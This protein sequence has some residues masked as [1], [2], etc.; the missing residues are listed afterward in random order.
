[1]AYNCVLINSLEAWSDHFISLPYSHCKMLG[2][3]LG[4]CASQTDFESLGA[5]E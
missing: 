4:I 2:L 1:M 5:D 3:Y